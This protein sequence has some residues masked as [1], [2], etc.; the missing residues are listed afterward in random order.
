ME[1]ETEPGYSPGSF[2]CHEALHV[3]YI[4]ANMIDEQICQHLAVSQNPEW[5]NIADTARD[6]LH[7]LY[8]KVGA[9]HLS[10]QERNQ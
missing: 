5:K 1:N 4:M 10:A 3:A 9:S 2:G 8:H 6:L 7:D